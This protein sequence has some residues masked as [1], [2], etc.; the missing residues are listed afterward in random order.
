MVI[1]IQNKQRNAI[2]GEAR[3]FPTELS[4]SLN[5]FVEKHWKKYWKTHHFG[6]FF[7]P[8]Y[9]GTVITQDMF[10]FCCMQE[11]HPCQLSQI[12]YNVLWW[13]FPNLNDSLTVLLATM[14]SFRKAELVDCVTLIKLRRWTLYA[15]NVDIDTYACI[16]KKITL[17]SFSSLAKSLLQNYNIQM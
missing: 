6:N 8:F 17:H 10:F 5:Y 11:D 13:T 15:C 9:F 1:I 7:S 2:F 16:Y 4:K 12:K 3:L 14:I